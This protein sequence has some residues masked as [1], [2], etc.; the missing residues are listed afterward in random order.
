MQNRINQA[1][2]TVKRVKL[3][4]L[5]KNKRNDQ[6]REVDVKFMKY[7]DS[8][9]QEESSRSMNFFRGIS[10]TVDRFSDENMIDFQF[11][12]ISVIKNIQQREQ[13]RYIPTPRNQWNRG[14]QGY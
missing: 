10:D 1:Q 3:Q 4:R 5:K 12:V 11:Q 8:I 7:M 6:L 9:A 2:G 13:N 14:P